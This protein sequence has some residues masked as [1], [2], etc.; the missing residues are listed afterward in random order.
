MPIEEIIVEKNVSC[1]TRDG[2]RLKADIYQPHQAGTYPVLL[3]RLPYGKDDPFFSH[4]YLDTHRMVRAGYIVVIQDVRGRYN[5][6]GDFFPFYDE[7]EDGY[8]AVEWAA[9]LPYSNGQVGMFGLSYYGFTQLLAAKLKPPHLKAIFP[10]QTLNDMR[11]NMVF[12]QGV[13]KLA[14]MKTWILESMVPDLLRRKYGNN[15]EVY[16]EKMQIWADAMD[17]LVDDF[18][19]AYEAGF[20]ILEKLG[21]AEEFYQVFNLDKNDEVWKRA[22]ILNAYEHID[23]PAIHVAGWYDSLLQ[24]TL[25]NYQEMQAKVDAPQRLIVGPWTHGNFSSVQAELEFGLRASQHF[26]DGQ[27]DLTQLHM[28]WFNRFL[29]ND[30]N[31]VDQEAPVKVFVMGRNEWRHAQSW[32]LENTDY[33]SF[34]LNHDF[35][36]SLAKNLADAGFDIFTHKPEEPVPTH[37]GQTL[38]KGVQTA[39]PKDQSVIETR[40]DVLLY[41][42]EALDK[43]IEVTG[44][45][46]VIL[47]AM[48]EAVET[49]FTAKLVDIYP[50]GRAINLVDGMSKVDFTD[51][52]GMQKIEIDLLATSNVFFNKHQIGLEV[53]STNHPKF[54]SPKAF[55]QTGQALPEVE[56]KVYYQGDCPSQL[57]LPL[58][59]S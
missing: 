44:P 49:T 32:P 36:L 42:T 23:Y 2:V 38:F 5:S 13:K 30:F 9:A 16:A 43:D 55:S 45:V 59:H 46:K 12:H 57:V 26:L 18:N 6:E 51:K 20:P 54:E 11:D 41:Q 33:Q 52:T 34:Y 28:R 56:Q 8:D 58:I 24:S 39:G 19:E 37:G 47:Y 4:R 21:V 7:A 22:S 14:S 35:H 15:M 31:G 50:D 10:T 3:T 17:Q 25:K 27:E 53:A 1:L 40:E 29:K 48:S